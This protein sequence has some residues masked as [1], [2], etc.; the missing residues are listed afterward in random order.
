M[1]FNID[2][3]KTDLVIDEENMYKYSKLIKKKKEEKST[4][5]TLSLH[6]LASLY[7]KNT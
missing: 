1:A 5:H 6:I 3:V 7:L 4:H 2:I